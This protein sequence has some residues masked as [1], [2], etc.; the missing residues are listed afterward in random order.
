MFALTASMTPSRL[1]ILSRAS[2]SSVLATRSCSV[3][4]SVSPSATYTT[5]RAI[6]HMSR[7]AALSTP[8]TTLC[9]KDDRTHLQLSLQLRHGFAAVCDVGD[10]TN[11]PARGSPAQHEQHAHATTLTPQ[12]SVLELQ[13][14]GIF[15]CRE[16]R[17][18]SGQLR[19]LCLQARQVR[20]ERV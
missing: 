7:S 10:A 4:F 20:L 2:R 1:D 14:Q 19:L 5:Q 9:H 16:L 15:L 8:A 12:Q 18:C 3:T 6:S 11:I 17:Q 13:L